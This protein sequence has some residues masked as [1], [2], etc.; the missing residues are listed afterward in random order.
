MQVSGTPSDVDRAIAS[1][2]N[3]QIAAAVDA[4]LRNV[5]H[6]HD[7]EAALTATQALMHARK[8]DAMLRLADGAARV[9]AP[10][11]AWQ[12]WPQAVQALTELGANNTAGR[13]LQQLLGHDEPEAAAAKGTL[14]ALLG[15]LKKTDWVATG[16]DDTLLAAIGAYVDAYHAGADP[17]WAGVNAVALQAAAGR[18]HLTADVKDPPATDQL[19]ALAATAP[20]P[21]SAWSIAT[22]LELRLA[23]GEHD[24]LQPLLQQLFAAH[25]ASGFVYTSL[26]RQLHDVWELDPADPLMVQLGDRTLASG[27]GEVLLPK[28]PDGYEKAFGVFAFVPIDVYEQGLGV[29]R[30]VGHLLLKGMMSVGTLFAVRGADLHPSLADHVV[31][32][33]NEHVV[34]DPSRDNGVHAGDLVAT[35][36]GVPGPDNK[37]LTFG[38]LRVVW[39]S[40]REELD[41]A[42][43]MSNDS[44]VQQLA[45]VDM[46]TDPPSMIDG[47]YVYVI[48]H[49][50][51]GGLQLSIRGN[52]MIDTDGTKIHYKAATDKGSS[53][54]PVFD[55]AW[56]LIGV[57]HL[58]SDNLSALNGK[59]GTYPG[60]EGNAIAAVRAA[61]TQ[62]PPTPDGV[63]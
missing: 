10:A 53:G 11:L 30:S 28:D 42:V 62:R 63:P 25:D 3:D 36:D 29:A 34:P 40:P 55:M 16:N 43:L 4:L 15:R 12:L 33:T 8:F 22:E 6:D 58:G 52:D 26:T 50:G 41:I 45:G 44:A 32:I 48:G 14:Y 37:A 27:S 46:A 24:A 39:R 2:S 19:L 17:L 51:Q 56:K 49:P 35:F 1:G 21:R 5:A 47:E 61:L 23:R 13:L 18:R 20:L 9:A 54:S 38:G 59:A 31:L 57:H 7:A 60:N